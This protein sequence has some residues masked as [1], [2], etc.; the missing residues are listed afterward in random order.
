MDDGILDFGD[1]ARQTEDRSALHELIRDQLT[2]AEAVGNDRLEIELWAGRLYP[3]G[4]R[5]NPRLVDRLDYPLNSDAEQLA[6]KLLAAF[7]R[8]VGKKYVGAFG[9]AFKVDEGDEVEEREPVTFQRYVRIGGKAP[10][11]GDMPNPPNL[12]GGQQGGQ[13]GQGWGGQQ[14]QGWGGQQGQ[15]QGQGQG[16]GSGGGGW[17]S[18]QAPSWGGG[19]GS[20]AGG[21]GGRVDWWNASLGA[22]QAEKEKADAW[23]KVL[24]GAERQ[25]GYLGEIIHWLHERDRVKDDRLMACMDYLLRLNHTVLSRGMNM[26]DSPAGGGG[27]MLA[28]MGGFAVREGL[29]WL[30]G[31]RGEGGGG[32]GDDWRAPPPLSERGT[33]P[34]PVFPSAAPSPSGGGD[35]GA[36]FDPH[37][38]SQDQITAIVKHRQ[39]DVL[40]AAAGEISSPGVKKVLAAAAKQL[41]GPGRG[42]GEGGE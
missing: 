30:F 23:G 31:D 16:W 41:R 26:L 35:G 9:L 29:S 36:A 12:W 38:L 7:K 21:G 40:Q 25:I 2:A 3:N 32:G 27:N 22:D 39:G 28:D 37:G 18:Q 20:W 24:G 1:L 34:S 13:Q 11:G 6:G 8:K 4:A 19:G 5:D 42:G 15:G 10:F 14:G 17:G 33:G